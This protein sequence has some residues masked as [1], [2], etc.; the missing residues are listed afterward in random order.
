[1]TVFSKL[2]KSELFKLPSDALNPNK[3]FDDY[4]NQYITD[5]EYGAETNMDNLYPENMKILAPLHIGKHIPDFFCIFR[6]DGTYNTETYM[7]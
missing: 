4:N 7:S 3:F 2:P 6:Y 1:M 5:Y